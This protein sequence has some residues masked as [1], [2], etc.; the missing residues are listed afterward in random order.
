MKKEYIE[1]IYAGWLA[2]VIGVR[3]GAPVE[4]WTYEKIKKFY[5]T[6][7]DYPQDYKLFAADDDTNGPLFFLRGLEDSGH[8]KDEGKDF[9]AQDVA[10]ALLNYAPYEHGFFW[11]GGYGI[12]TEHTAYLN[13]RNGISA[14]RSGSI[15]QNGAATAEQIG[16]Q[17]FIDTWGLV[18]PGNPDLAARLAREAEV[19]HMT[20]T[21]FTEASLLQH[22]SAMP[23]RKVTSAASLKRDF[24]TF[25]PTVNTQEQFALSCTSMTDIPKA[26]GRTASN[27]STKALAMTGIPETAISFRTSVS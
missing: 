2:K 22:A 13:L 24:P 12:S 18:A 15:E 9:C 5:G 3:Y 1:K 6:L 19:S 21:G 27:I 8:Y 25:L 11:W 7:D 23:S 17:I 26:P 4:S 16:G 14:P 20:G 10:D